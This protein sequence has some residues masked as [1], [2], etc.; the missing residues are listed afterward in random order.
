MMS[1]KE[2]LIKQMAA[3]EQRRL[4]Q[5]FSAEELGDRKRTQLLC[6][7]KQLA[8]DMPS[9]DGVFLLELFLQQ[10]PNNVAMYGL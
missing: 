10:L 4:Q 2:Q 7:L 8:G 3:S 1:L 6:Q 9:A 5:L